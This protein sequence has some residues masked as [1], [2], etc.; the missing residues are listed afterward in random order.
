MLRLSS[1][2]ELRDW[3]KSRDREWDVDVKTGIVRLREEHK[4]DIEVLATEL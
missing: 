2:D 1:A 3:A 4:A